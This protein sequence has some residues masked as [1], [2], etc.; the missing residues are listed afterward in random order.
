MAQAYFPARVTFPTKELANFSNFS[1]DRQLKVEDVQEA[2]IEQK[3]RYVTLGDVYFSSYQRV[4][5]GL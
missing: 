2:Y 5:V 1:G 3:D 4:F